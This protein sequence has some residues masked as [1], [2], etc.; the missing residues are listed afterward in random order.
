MPALISHSQPHA[1]VAYDQGRAID[2]QEYLASVRHMARL[3][4][5]QGYVLNLCTNRYHFAVVMG[6]ALLRHQPMLLPSTRT[7]AMLSQLSRQY[8][9]LYAVVEQD[10]SAL[11]LPH[12]GFAA[13]PKEAGGTPAFLE[14]P[15]IAA[16]QI[17]AYVFTSGSTGLPIPHAKRWGQLVHNA[18][19]E[20]ERVRLH[21]PGDHGT[22]TAFAVT[23][24]VPAQHMYGFE[25]TVLLPMHNRAAL[26]A[27]HP[28]YPADIAEALH[29]VP[30]PRV[31]V[32]TPFHLR[33]L[34]ESQ[35]KVPA[36]DLLMSATAPLPP[37]LAD[38]AERTLSAPLL[39]IYGCTETGQI[40]TR[41][42]TSTQLWECYKDV[43][44]LQQ[45]DA[46]NEPCF[47]ARGGHV[48]GSVALGDVLEL[49]SSTT[50]K[51]LGRQADMVNIA[52]KR[53]SLAYLNHELNSIQGVT[54][55]AFYLFDNDD[56]EAQARVQRPMAFVV[57]PGLSE[58]DLA[59]ALRERIDPV[60]MPRPI[61]LLDH[62]PR[63]STGK[64][65]Q[66]ALAELAH[67]MKARAH[68]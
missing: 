51:L 19:A 36:V 31:L 4:P 9:G 45:P 10:A 7:P 48:E 59:S 37:Q 57:A 29:R 3:L 17:A 22:D 2:A 40:A 61:C 47:L 46:Q 14:V 23:G 50:F 32:T 53:T 67:A 43:E 6:A 25:S 49:H 35:T 54:D 58:A 39:E 5:E 66:Q 18:Q 16:D 15:Q 20:G 30:R 34:I 42:T 24:T 38:Q 28:F 60:F 27:S 62:L 1:I 12:I 13:A 33:T 64:L 44:I 21:L 26:D 8:A 55:G 11:D 52:G 68:G 63:N 41:R 56:M 65:P